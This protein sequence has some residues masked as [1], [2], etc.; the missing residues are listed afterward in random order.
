MCDPSVTSVPDLMVAEIARL[1]ESI[2]NLVRATLLCRRPLNCNREFCGRA[3]RCLPTAGRLP[4]DIFRSAFV[5]APMVAVLPLDTP[6]EHSASPNPRSPAMPFLQLS[7][8]DPM[9]ALRLYRMR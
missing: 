6:Q 2:K 4:V 8:T 3:S 7:V 1:Q 9:L 5:L